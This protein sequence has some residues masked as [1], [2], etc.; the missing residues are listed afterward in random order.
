MTNREFTALV[1]KYKRELEFSVSVGTINKNKDGKFKKS[2]SMGR[3]INTGKPL[4][5]QAEGKTIEACAQKLAEKYREHVEGTKN[6]MKVRTFGEV[7]DEWYKV[8][9]A[10]ANISEGSKSNYKTDLYMHI[11]PKLKNFDIQQLKKKDYQNLLNT[12]AGRGESLVKKI[13]MTLLRV[14]KYAAE[15]EYI[16]ERS[17]TLSF[18]KMKP[19]NKRD[20]LTEE[21]IALLFRA[22]KEY[23]PAIAFIALLTTGMRPSELFRLTYKDVDFE[24]NVFHI[25]KSKTESGIRIVPVPQFLMDMIIEDKR[26]LE[27][28]GLNPTFVFHQQKEPLKAHNSST[29]NQ[30]WKTTLREMDILNGAKTHR[31]QIT[32]STIENKDKLTVYCMRHTYCTLLNDCGIGT[33]YKKRLMGHTLRD[34]I[35]DGVYTHTTE[36]KI[37]KAAQPFLN[38]MERMYSEI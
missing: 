28:Q 17:M 2:L 16:P 14:I 19:L 27:A 36:D 37:I 23:F 22:Q 8:E 18:P 12:F 24:K 26:S 32:E 35:T 29:M 20:V 6:K 30:T 13:R 21:Q 33:Y 15:N 9:I 7:A 5:I 38:L 10:K 31:N 4:R 1:E 25:E 3:D 34:S 11:I